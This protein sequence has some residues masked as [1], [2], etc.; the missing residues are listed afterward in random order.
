MIRTTGCI[1]LAMRRVPTA[2]GASH[3]AFIAALLGSTSSSTATLS[4]RRHLLGGGDSKNPYTVLGIKQGASKEEIKK[5]YRVMARKHHPDAPGGSHEKFQ[6]ISQAYEQIKTGV[7]VQKGDGSGGDGAADNN[8][9]YSKFRYTTRGHKGKVSYDDFYAE[10]HGGGTKKGMDFDDDET[11][12][13][14]KRANPLGANE[15]LV[16]AWFRV[17]VAWTI[18]F[19]TLRVVLFLSFPP[20]HQSTPK[21]PLP[22]KPRK[23]APPKPISSQPVLA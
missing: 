11:P 23:P 5:A 6:E 14:K 10:M 9:R 16:Q 13:G 15:K 20:K 22:E 19:V 8:N 12:D 3:D 17:I 1:R 4:Q 7:W 21:K 18:I 2:S